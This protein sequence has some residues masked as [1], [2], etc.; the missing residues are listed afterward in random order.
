[1]ARVAEWVR[2]ANV[3]PV[4]HVEAKCDHVSTIVPGGVRDATQVFV[5]RW[6]AGTSLARVQLDQGYRFWCDGASRRRRE[7]RGLGRR[8][9]CPL[10]FFARAAR[11]K[12]E[13]SGGKQAHE[14]VYG[15]AQTAVTAG[16]VTQW[17]RRGAAA[18]LPF[19][20]TEGSERDA[21]ID[22]SGAVFHTGLG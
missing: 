2:P 20:S 13:S 7:H 15:A 6:A 14:P 21:S 1:M 12:Q 5:C 22:G 17:T 16:A 18:R 4:V 9:H 11:K 8:A 3:V 19:G 10:V